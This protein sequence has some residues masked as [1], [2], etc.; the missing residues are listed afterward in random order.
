MVDRTQHPYSS[1][2]TVL[3]VEALER[4]VDN[5]FECV[6]ML[7]RATSLAQGDE[8]QKILKIARKHL[9]LAECARAQLPLD[10]GIP[11]KAVRS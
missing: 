6:R 5:L 1:D 9:L 11:A 4:A 10:A 3:R 7:M 2:A 8:H